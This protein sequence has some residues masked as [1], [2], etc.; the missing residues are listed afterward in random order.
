MKTTQKILTLSL[1]CLSGAVSAH[2][3]LEELELVVV[4]PHRGDRTLLEATSTV[5]LID[6][7]EIDVSFPQSLS[8]VVERVPGV[9]V[10]QNGA[11]GA[12]SSIF[13]RGT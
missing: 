7:V 10:A 5:S 8:E 12:A 1:A 13:L 2:A 9:N 11:Q 3:Q 4:T 6:S